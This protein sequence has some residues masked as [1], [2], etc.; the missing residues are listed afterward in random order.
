[1]PFSR[2][3]AKKSIKKLSK[4]KSRYSKNKK[5]FSKSKKAKLVGGR[6]VKDK[7]VKAKKN[8]SRKTR[9]QRGGNS[10]PNS[11]VCGKPFLKRANLVKHKETCA[12]YSRIK[13]TERKNKIK[14]A[15]IDFDSPFFISNPNIGIPD[16]KAIIKFFEKMQKDKV[17]PHINNLEQFDKHIEGI[18]Q[19]LVSK[20]VPRRD[21][22]SHIIQ[23][24][25]K[26]YPDSTFKKYKSQM[27]RQRR[28]EIL[29]A[30]SATKQR[31]SIR[32]FEE[33]YILNIPQ[34]NHVHEGFNHD[35]IVEQYD[36]T[37]KANIGPRDT[38]RESH[39][40]GRLDTGNSDWDKKFFERWVKRL[41][42]E[43]DALPKSDLH[44]A[45]QKMISG[46][47]SA[48]LFCQG[49]ENTF[50][51]YIRTN[52]SNTW[53]ILYND[54]NEPK[55]MEHTGGAV[56][57]NYI[58]GSE[59]HNIDAQRAMAFSVGESPLGEYTNIQPIPWNQLYV[60][61]CDQLKKLLLKCERLRT[62]LSKPSAEQG[63][64]YITIPGTSNLHYIRQ[65]VLL[66]ITGQKLNI[67]H[68]PDM[69]FN[70]GIYTL[71]A[72]P[73]AHPPEKTMQ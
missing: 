32:E 24:F 54:T 3:Y 22:K 70:F 8:K 40:Y 14:R 1:M 41:L 66:Q 30:K 6:R 26:I 73:S 21:L 7:R 56:A 23:F 38:V 58:K 35:S 65:K 45:A 44:S 5:K 4:K 18:I 25:I 63:H 42:L 39:L 2:K 52:N 48:M 27:I 13:E 20:G 60:A 34:W 51:T 59:H 31:L 19:T 17:K 9:K 53:V 72:N 68:P 28:E 62:R 57:N 64:T 43:S 46:S 36:I 16:K 11:C 33:T 71:D 15:G 10:R 67:P 29:Y 50:E 55:T 37:Y 49:A 61:R 12:E 47:T 69:T